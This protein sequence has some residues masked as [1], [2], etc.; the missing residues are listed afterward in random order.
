MTPGLSRADI[1][2]LLDEL[3]AELTARHAKADVFLVGGAAIAIAYDATRSTRDLDAVFRPTAVVRDAATAVAQRRHLSADWLN[4]AVRGFLPGA[5][6]DAER[7]YESP[8]LNVDVASARY[9]LAM[10]LF[11]AR[12]ETDTDDIVPV[13][14]PDMPRH[15]ADECAELRWAPAR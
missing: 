7:F 11:A 13:W 1:R 6:P 10:K 3:S 14:L 9:L 15:R 2:A 12:A 4:D 8:S 5:D